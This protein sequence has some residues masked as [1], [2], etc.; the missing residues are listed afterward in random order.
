MMKLIRELQNE[1]ER[2]RSKILFSNLCL[3]EKSASSPIK[4]STRTLAVPSN[5]NHTIHLFKDILLQDQGDLVANYTYLLFY[6]YYSCHFI[7]E[8]LFNLYLLAYKWILCNDKVPTIY[9]GNYGLQWL[10]YNRFL[11]GRA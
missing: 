11:K 1:S 2:P 5:F 6:L 9:F 7:E 3:R 10:I 8:Y 4:C